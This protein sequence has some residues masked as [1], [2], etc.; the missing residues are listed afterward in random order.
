MQYKNIT[1]ARSYL[2]KK[3][4]DK[5]IKIFFDEEKTKTE[6]ARLIRTAREAAGFRPLGEPEHGLNCVKKYLF[7]QPSNLL[8]LKTKPFKCWTL[9]TMIHISCLIAI[10]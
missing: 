9:I 8:R 4:K 3:L 2:N 5:T 6:I 1:P 7:R 10:T